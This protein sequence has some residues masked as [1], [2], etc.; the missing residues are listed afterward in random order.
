MAILPLRSGML[1]S[2]EFF[3]TGLMTSEPIEAKYFTL[4]AAD[5]LRALDVLEINELIAEVIFGL[6]NSGEPVHLDL[7]DECLQSMGQKIGKNSEQFVEHLVE[8]IRTITKV[9]GP[10]AVVT[11]FRDATKRWRNLKDT[12]PNRGLDTPPA[13]ALLALLALAAEQMRRTDVEG[14]DS[15]LVGA[16]NYY[17]RFR[18]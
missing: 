12:R 3:W 10:K 7:E 4:G 17:T 2:F 5:P 14:D 1:P 11:E 8:S 13:L 15:D 16:G 6:Q 9:S 18:Q